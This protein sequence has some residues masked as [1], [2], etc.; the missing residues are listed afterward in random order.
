ML[1]S[2]WIWVNKH[3]FCKANFEYTIDSEWWNMNIYK[4]V[5]LIMNAMN[6]WIKNWIFTLYLDDHITNATIYVFKLI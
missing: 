5:R 2:D 4:I 6:Q 3:R 1:V